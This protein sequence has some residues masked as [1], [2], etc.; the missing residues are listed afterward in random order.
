MPNSYSLNS[1]RTVSMLVFGSLLFLLSVT[2]AANERQLPDQFQLVGDG[3]LSILSWDIY[4]SRLFTPDGRYTEDSEELILAI[5][6]LRNIKNKDLVKH[7]RKQW[8]HLN[9]DKAV[10]GK[11]TEELTRL[12]PDV[13]PGDT[14]AMHVTQGATHFYFNSQHTGSIETPDFGPLFASI[15]LSPETSQPKLRK[16][17]LGE[18]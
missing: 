7:T 14:L 15:W 1:V 4:E 8:R 2:A 10:Y 18:T 9:I 3:L 17:L 12:W 11:F 6:Y 13:S 16:Q 5:T